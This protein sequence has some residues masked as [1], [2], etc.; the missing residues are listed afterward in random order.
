MKFI[1]LLILGY[2]EIIIFKIQL[3]GKVVQLIIQW[4]II[5]L[6]S[7]LINNNLVH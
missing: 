1:Q 2:L 4:K 5:K 7:L 6:I 3:I